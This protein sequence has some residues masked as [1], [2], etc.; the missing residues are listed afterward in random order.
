MIA[1]IV[2][3]SLIAC[4]SVYLIYKL[5]KGWREGKSLAC[6]GCSACSGNCSLCKKDHE[7]LHEEFKKYKLLQNKASA[8]PSQTE[9]KLSL[10]I[11]DKRT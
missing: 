8:N 5:V 4:Y 9:S 1:N 6:M 3:I 2:I 7:K 11:Q 10:M